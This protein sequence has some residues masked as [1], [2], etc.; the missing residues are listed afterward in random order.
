V[1]TLADR[2][3]AGEYEPALLAWVGSSE[4]EST[5]PEIQLG[6][7]TFSVPARDLLPPLDKYAKLIV[8]EA[9][10]TVGYVEASHGCVHKC[11]HCPLPVIYDGRI[12]IVG[13]ETVVEDIGQLV[14]LGAEHIT[15]GDP[16]FLNGVKHSMRVV[17]QMHERWP[18]LTFDITT[19]V[20]HVLEYPEVWPE[21]SSAGLL[22]AIC[23]VECVSDPIL[24]RLD[25]GHT[26]AQAS[27]AVEVLRAHG[28]E[29]RPSLLPFT[30]WTTGDDIAAIF[31][32]VADHDLIGNV[33]PVHYSIRLLI[34]EGSLVLDVDDIA[35]YL[36]DY[37]SESLSYSWAPGDPAMDE[38]QSSLAAIAESGA[39][40]GE[41]IA[42]TFDRMRQVVSG[43]TAP[44]VSSCCVT[45]RPRMSEPWF[46]CAEPMENQF[47]TLEGVGL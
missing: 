6:R 25:K 14:E 12:R 1:G 20:E 10:K 40:S 37:N 47:A 9:E 36:G 8:G 23:A 32:W 24:E 16:D 11:R 29:M 34:P 21:L 30:P 4:D 41:P 3:I 2:V 39:S 46:C 13:A 7:G 15:F 18:A 19:K 17:E 28:V 45:E 31:D 33:D 43:G 27:E 22:Y 35:P 42:V 5:L 44:T 38:L 26:A